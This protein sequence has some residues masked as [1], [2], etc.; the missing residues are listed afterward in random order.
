MYYIHE[1]LTKDSHDSAQVIEHRPPSLTDVHII[2]DHRQ[3]SY[4]CGLPIDRVALE[5]GAEYKDRETLASL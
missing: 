2:V 3:Q 4:R 5:I 1:D